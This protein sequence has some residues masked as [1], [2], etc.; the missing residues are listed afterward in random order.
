MT[1]G[2]LSVRMVT[3]GIDFGSGR[4]GAHLGVSALRLDCG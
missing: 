3:R 1:G 4:S 2:R